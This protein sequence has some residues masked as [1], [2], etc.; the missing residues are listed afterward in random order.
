ME[1]GGWRMLRLK[2]TNGQS[3]SSKS[4]SIEYDDEDEKLGTFVRILAHGP[5]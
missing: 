1:D 3:S 5:G 4:Q 2:P